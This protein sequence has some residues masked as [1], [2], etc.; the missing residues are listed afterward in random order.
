[1]GSPRCV[2]AAY[3][4]LAQHRGLPLTTLDREL[5]VAAGQA[6]VGLPDPGE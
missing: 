4:E 3:L 2:D 6:G 1:M 5:C